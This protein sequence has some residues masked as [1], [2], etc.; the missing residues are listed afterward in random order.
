M[1]R[2]GAC[3]L[4]GLALAG[5]A[6][7]RPRVSVSPPPPRVF[8]GA[9]EEGVA[10]WYGR[11]YHGRATTSGEIYDMEQM[12]A[13]HR[14]LPLGTRVRV[15]NL[16]NGREVEVRINDRGPFVENR[17]LDLS[18]AAARRIQMIGPGTA[19]VRLRI[20]GLPDQVVPGFFTVQVGSFKSRLNAERLRASL[21]R[22][23]GSA[24]LREYDS[25]RGLFYRVLVGHERD[26]VGAEE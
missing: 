3:V 24:I 5:C 7:K 6:K 8:P 25:P 21:A 13:A 16:A 10:S 4:L 17:V 20:V 23:H 22:E 18:R 19:H 9:T 11:P 14:T 26:Q 12:T 15:E 1:R 2:A